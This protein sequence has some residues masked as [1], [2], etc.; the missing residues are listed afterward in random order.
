[1]MRLN[2]YF[3]ATWDELVNKVSWP[4]WQELQSSAILVMVASALIAFI[5][6]LMDTVFSKTMKFFYDM[7][8]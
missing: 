1:M 2:A 7:M 8:S 5:I 3:K 4:T 6:W